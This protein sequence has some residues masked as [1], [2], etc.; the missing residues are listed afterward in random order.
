M[1]CR[2]KALQVLVC[3]QLKHDSKI[4]LASTLSR[5]VINAFEWVA[6]KASGIYRVQRLGVVG[7]NTRYL[8]FVSHD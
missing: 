2:H 1:Q 8:L 7:T 6:Q 3:I 5:T 4:E